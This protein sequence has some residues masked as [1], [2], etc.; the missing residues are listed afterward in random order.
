MANIRV[1]GFNPSGSGVR[2]ENTRAGAFAPGA[3]PDKLINSPPTNNEPNPKPASFRKSL[4]DIFPLLSIA[5]LK[6]VNLS[7]VMVGL[8]IP[9]FQFLFVL[10]K[11]FQDISCRPVR[12][13]R[14][15]F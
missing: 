6:W 2:V 13:R 14:R 10:E 11:V 4:L 8:S 15:V 12:A 7:S 9:Q 1:T 3:H 5:L